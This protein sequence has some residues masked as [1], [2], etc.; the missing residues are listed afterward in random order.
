[1][2]R[3]VWLF[4]AGSL[5]AVAAAL[6]IGCVFG[7][8]SWYR[9]LGAGDPMVRLAER[10]SPIPAGYAFAIGAVLCGWS[11]YAFSGSGALPRLPLLR[12][13]LVGICAV[14]LLRAAALPILLAYAT[15]P[16]RSA[17][18]MVWSS[19]IVLVYGLVHL[20]GIWASWTALKAP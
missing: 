2:I 16:G 12:P 11:A 17:T 14:Y 4:A 20:I 8:P 3:N 19:I 15:G 18:F 9:F 6:H 7:G 5:S 1:M 13:V 10:G